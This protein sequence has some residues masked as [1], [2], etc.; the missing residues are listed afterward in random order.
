MAQCLIISDE[1]NA[2]RKLRNSI[3]EC[4]H[5]CD[6]RSSD[7]IGS[8]PL[9]YQLYDLI[10]CDTH[11]KSRS[12]FD[13]TKSI[14]EEQRHLAVI[15]IVAE[16]QSDLSGKIHKSGALD[17]ISLPID[18]QRVR[19]TL[20]NALYRQKIEKRLQSAQ[21]QIVNSEKMAAIG[22]LAAGV[23]HEINNPV[24]FVAS[25]LNTLK[26]YQKSLGAVI[27]QYRKLLTEISNEILLKNNNTLVAKRCSRIK[28]LEK[29]FDL[30]YLIGDMRA[31]LSESLS[32]VTQV[33]KIVRDL[34]A[35]VHP[36]QNSPEFVDI[37]KQLDATLTLVWNKLKYKINV[38]K[39]YGKLPLVKCWASQLN[40]VFL[41]IVVNAIQ[42]IEE[43]GTISIKTRVVEDEHVEICIGDTGKG[44][45]SEDL[46]KIFE[47]F[48]TTKPVGQG[49]G[50]GLH[51]SKNIIKRHN[52]DITV[53]S[54]SGYGTSF[55]I[56]LPVDIETTDGENNF[57]KGDEASW[58]F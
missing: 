22:Q 47:P 8:V 55:K 16:V 7:A 9:P 25:N 32:G 42:A 20:T 40:Q 39:E 24:G 36:G 21:E 48:F 50:L 28:R 5:Q 3:V 2:S 44:I 43:K 56:Q 41:N 45:S 31:V 33:K 17:Y 54:R 35:F 15:M 46:T 58:L 34:K 38:Q 26:H 57:I 10:F 30:N 51:M 13:L 53:E 19:V 23:A 14:L 1:A 4:G 27:V 11:L 49:T 37:H 6:L 18:P 52:G 12:G 29:K